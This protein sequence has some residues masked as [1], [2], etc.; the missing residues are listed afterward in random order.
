[1]EEKLRYGKGREAEAVMNVTCD[2]SRGQG[3]LPE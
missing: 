3:V 2:R 1:M